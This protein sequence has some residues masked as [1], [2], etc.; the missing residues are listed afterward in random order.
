MIA[1]M[2]TDQQLARLCFAALGAHVVYHVRDEVR[3]VSQQVL[4]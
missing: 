2:L 4:Q 3:N 1:P